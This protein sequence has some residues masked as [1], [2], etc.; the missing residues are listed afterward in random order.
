VRW[1]SALHRPLTL[2][3]RSYCNFV[4]V[5]IFVIFFLLFF[6]FLLVIN[7]KSSLNWIL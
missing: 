7:N 5:F 3:R 1:T 2:T 4:F 6:F